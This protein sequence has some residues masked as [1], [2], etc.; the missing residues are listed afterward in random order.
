MANNLGN[1]VGLIKSTFAPQKIYVLWSHVLNSLFPNEQ[2]LKKYNTVN[3]TWEELDS[4]KGFYLPPVIDFNQ[5]AP[6]VSPT[7]GDSYLIA[8]TGTSGMWVGHENNHATWL[9]NSWNYVLPKIGAVSKNMSNPSSTKYLFFGGVW[10]VETSASAGPVYL[11]G[12]ETTLNGVRIIIEGSDVMIQQY[13][14]T[15]WQDLVSL[16]SPV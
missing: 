3:S 12:T 13:D 7:I 4:S 9:G 1:V 16:A 6:P 5:T 15:T 2:V 14:G 11:R 8:A 10:I